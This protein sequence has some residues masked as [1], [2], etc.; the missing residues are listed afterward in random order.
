MIVTPFPDNVVR[1]T[2]ETATKRNDFM[3]EMADEIIIGYAST[4][5]NIAELLNNYND[6]KTIKN[7]I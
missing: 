6:K 4:G 7:I 1:I 5:G 2:S 3:V